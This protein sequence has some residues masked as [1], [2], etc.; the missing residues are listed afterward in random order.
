MSRTRPGRSGDRGRPPPSHADANEAPES[1][2]ASALWLTVV[3]VGLGRISDRFGAPAGVA[4]LLI[5]LVWA[6]GDD[7]TQNEFVRGLLFG[8]HGRWWLQALGLVLV[9]DI[10]FGY[11]VRRRWLDGES[12][13][14]KRIAAEKRR[15]Q[16]KLLGREL[17]HT[18]DL[19]GSEVDGKAE[20]SQ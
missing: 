1:A 4:A 2:G 18:K 11:S 19:T 15:L 13:E 16:E 6:F 12:T 5:L 17:A 10:L 14:M 9:V 3:A 8:D 7:A 20:D